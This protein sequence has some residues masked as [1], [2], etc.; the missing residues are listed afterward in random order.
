MR[1]GERLDR[2]FVCLPF[3]RFTVSVLPY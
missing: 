1:S 3:D 2:S